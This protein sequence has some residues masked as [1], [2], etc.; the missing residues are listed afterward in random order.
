MVKPLRLVMEF[1]HYGD[2]YSVPIRCFLFSHVLLLFC[3]SEPLTFLRYLHD[4]NASLPW[5]QRLRIGLGIAKGMRYSSPLSRSLFLSRSLVLYV[6]CLTGFEIY[7]RPLASCNPQRSA[8]PEHLRM[9]PFSC[10]SRSIMYTTIFQ[11][12]YLTLYQLEK[13]SKGFTA[14]VHTLPTCNALT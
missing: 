14:K 7:A 8:E 12:V 10:L 6:V 1:M 9:L 5:V 11:L 4:S 3:T 13:T 2:L